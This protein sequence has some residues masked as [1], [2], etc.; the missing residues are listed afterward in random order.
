[1]TLHSAKGL[2]FPLVFLA[3]MEEGLFPHNLSLHD[4]PRLEE[5]RRLAYVGMTRAMR[6][7]FLTYAERRRLHGSE[8]V[9]PPSRFL[10]EIPTELLQEVRLRGAVTRPV[11]ARATRDDA[12]FRLG[13]A[14]LHAKFGD[15]VVL[16]LEGDG[17]SARVQVNFRDV[18]TKWL[19]LAYAKLQPL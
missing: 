3:G 16:G 1:M 7:L 4:A 5:E 10:S 19:M 8:S 13:Q 17:A 6:H 12:P 2:E 18:G 15:G 14:V 11:S 9:A